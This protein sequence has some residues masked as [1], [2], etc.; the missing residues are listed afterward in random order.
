[1]NFYFIK[2]VLFLFSRNQWS[3]KTQLSFW[4][5]GPFKIML[6]GMIHCL[7]VLFSGIECS[8]GMSLIR[9]KEVI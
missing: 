1:M 3:W 2:D 4:F 7:S 8:Y 9:R 6:Y 5:G